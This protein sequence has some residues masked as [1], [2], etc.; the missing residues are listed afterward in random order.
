MAHLTDDPWSDAHERDVEALARISRTN[1]WIALV[2][3]AIV[4]L[5]V[6]GAVL[7]VR[8]AMFGGACFV[9]CGV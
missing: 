3:V 5:V 7:L 8:S 4:V 9:E 6:V 2:Y 1:G